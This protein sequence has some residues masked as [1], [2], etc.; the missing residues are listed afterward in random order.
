[1][2]KEKENNPEEQEKDRDIKKPGN[3]GEEGGIS[4]KQ[5][6]FNERKTGGLRIA[7]GEDKPG[8]EDFAAEPGDA[9]L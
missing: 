4:R 3:P 8:K 5:S 7:E 6:G 9:Q 2:R 1:M